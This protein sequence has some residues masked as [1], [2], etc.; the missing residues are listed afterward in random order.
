MEPQRRQPRASDAAILFKIASNLKNIHKNQHFLIK[1]P[2]KVP[3]NSLLFHK[4]GSDQCK[5]LCF[6]KNSQGYKMK[7]FWFITQFLA[8]PASPLDFGSKKIMKLRADL[9][10]TI[11]WT[12]ASHSPP[13]P[14]N[15]DSRAKNSRYFTLVVESKKPTLVPKSNDQIIVPLNWSQNLNIIF[16]KCIMSKR[17]NQQV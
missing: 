9:P 10:H 15:A 5:F 16:H 13:K 8:F 7:K 4:E 6:W 11:H 2:Y 3:K 12:S 1:I 14:R 17:L